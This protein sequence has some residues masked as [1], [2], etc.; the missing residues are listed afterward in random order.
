MENNLESARPYTSMEIVSDLQAEI[1][2]LIKN[3]VFRISDMLKYTKRVEELLNENLKEIKDERLREIARESLIKFSQEQFRNV[4]NLLNFGQLPVIVAFTKGY[5]LLDLKGLQEQVNNKVA[6]L[7]IR[8]IEN[9][10]SNLANSQPKVNNRQALY[11]YAE[12]FERYNENQAMVSELKQKTKLVVCD[13]HSN[14]SD[15]CFKWQGRVY[16]LDGTYGKTNDGREYVP[17]EVATQARDKYGNVN[18]LLG[19]NCRHKL[20][21]YGNGVKPPVVTKAEQKRQY[22]INN[23]QRLY[24]R[25]IRAYKEKAELSILDKSKYKKKSTEL[26]KEYKEFCQKNNVVEYRSRLK[27]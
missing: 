22:E 2:M 16:S 4:V 3:S 8:Q 19:Y 17:L 1:K 15:R 23:E 24:E 5:E 18:G 10:F 9:A 11:G 6:S 12:T 13:T 26:V 27:I 21:P 25:K 20:I 7:K 14:C